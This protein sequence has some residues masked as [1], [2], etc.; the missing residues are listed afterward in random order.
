MKR[1]INSIDIHVLKIDVESLY[2][3]SSDYFYNDDYMSKSEKDQISKLALKSTQKT[4]HNLLMK[5]CI[6]I[7][8]YNI[9][10]AQQSLRIENIANVYDLDK[11]YLFNQ[12]YVY[13][14]HILK[15]KNINILV[16]VYYKSHTE[17]SKFTECL[18]FIS[19]YCG[20]KK[21]VDIEKI[22]NFIPKNKNLFFKGVRKSIINTTF[23]IKVY[24]D[25]RCHP[26]HSKRIIHISELES[27]RYKLK[28]K[29]IT[30]N[31]P[32]CNCKHEISSTTIDRL[33]TL[34]RTIVSLNCNHITSSLH[35]KE[36]PFSIDIDKFTYGTKNFSK[37]KA[38]IFFINN[39]KRLTNATQ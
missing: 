24:D 25:Y 27:H 29:K 16:N 13:H 2:K 10:E 4:I 18:L 26:Q 12:I 1:L 8:I 3:L 35:I 39:F 23:G 38:Q 28:N 22:E 37:E 14:K 9:S 11:L 34:K 6:N 32:I 20:K 36:G 31:C 5:L 15:I 17:I 30:I 21:T 7:E 19:H 33:I